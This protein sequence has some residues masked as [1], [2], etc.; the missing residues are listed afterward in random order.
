MQIIKHLHSIT[1]WLW[2]AAQLVGPTCWPL[3]KGLSTQ[4][5]APYRLLTFFLIKLMIPILFKTIWVGLLPLEH[6]QHRLV[7]YPALAHKDDAWTSTRMSW[8]NWKIQ[9]LMVFAWTLHYWHQDSCNMQLS[10]YNFSHIWELYF[11]F[12]STK[13]RKFCLSTLAKLYSN[14]KNSLRCLLF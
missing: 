10:Q 1:S 3:L 11:Q 12:N 6:R 8:Q 14:T 5:S 9:C 2:L 13:Q 7:L 4:C